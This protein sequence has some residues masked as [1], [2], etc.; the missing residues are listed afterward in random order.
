MNGITVLLIATLVAVVF[1]IKKS[2]QISARDALEKLKGGALVID[3]RSPGEFGSGHLVRSINIP[4]DEIESALPRRVPGKQQVLLL[5][6]ASG[7]RSGMAKSKLKTMG[8]GN[9]YNL[10]SYG[11]AEKIVAQAT[12]N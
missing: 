1:F 8:Y 2:G 5:H 11:R 12:G 7:M 3:V 10:G 6:C 4:L 9:A